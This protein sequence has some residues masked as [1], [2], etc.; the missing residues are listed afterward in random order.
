M[1]SFGAR[2]VGA[3]Q[4]K[5]ATFEEVEHDRTATGQAAVVVVL[6]QLA[7]GI[8]ALRF[9]SVRGVVLAVVAGSIGWVIGAAVVLVIGTRLFPA[10]DTEADMGQML[11]TLGFAEA[12]GMLG[13]FGL[14]PAL[15]WPIFAVC[16][17]WILIAMVIAVRQALDYT[18]TT[19]AIVVCIV[20]WIVMLA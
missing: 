4:L 1:A 14:V 11:R 3:M 2:I 16:S 7:Q 18:S 12:A 9:G 17:V 6:S 13:V 8:G 10:K 15:N 19:R 20:A 5:A